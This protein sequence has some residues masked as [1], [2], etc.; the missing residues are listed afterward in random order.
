MKP[1]ETVVHTITGKCEIVRIV[2]ETNDPI[3]ESVHLRISLLLSKQLH[4]LK[5]KV[6]QPCAF[7]VERFC[8]FVC[9]LDS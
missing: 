2:E 1:Y 4:N 3:K 8:L 6:F 9:V 7:E 5:C